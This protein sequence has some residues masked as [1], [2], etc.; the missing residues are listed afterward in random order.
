MNTRD[1]P[2]RL[3]V[4]YFYSKPIGYSREIQE[5]YDHLE[6]DDLVVNNLKST[7]I[8]SRTSEGLLLQVSGS[9]DV[10][11]N[12]VRCLT[13]FFLPLEF[14]FEELYQFPSRTR[15]ETDLVL[16]QDGNIDLRLL[17]REYLILALP[18]KRLC[19]TD[20][21]GLCVVCGANL[22]DAICEHQSSP[23]DLVN[24]EG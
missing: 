18:I 20:C 3:N 1:N 15:E 8:A 24:L 4:G 16:P 9:A 5:D 13:D 12:C 23:S 14:D 10:E 2:L 7:I 11:T 19:K 17:F 6:L 22:N 21:K